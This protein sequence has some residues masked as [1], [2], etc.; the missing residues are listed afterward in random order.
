M[1]L[2]ARR[3]KKSEEKDEK[4]NTR[5][6]EVFQAL[7][8]AIDG[9]ALSKL[10][11]FPRRYYS[12]DPDGSG[13]RVVLVE[14]DGPGVVRLVSDEALINDI[15]TYTRYDLAEFKAFQITYRQAADAAKYWRSISKPVCMPAPFRWPGEAG[16]TFRRLP[17]PPFID[18][19]GTHTKT[20]NTLLAKMS[21]AQAFVAWIGSLFFGEAD[22]H[23]Y[24]WLFSTGGHGKGCINRFLARVFGPAYCSKQPPGMSD[25]YW[26]HGLM[27]KRLVVFPDCNNHKFVSSGLFK[28]LTGGDPIDVEAKYAMGFTIKPNCKF[29]FLSNERP[30]ISSEKADQRRVIYC[31]LNGESVWEADFEDRLWAEGGAFLGTCM[32]YY[33]GYYPNGGPVLSDAEEIAN[34]V[35]TLESEYQETFDTYFN[36]TPDEDEFKKNWVTKGLNKKLM[37]IFRNDERRVREFL[38]WM[39]RTHG[40]KYQTVRHGLTTWKAYKRLAA[41]D[42][43]PPH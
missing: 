22:I 19:D 31:E 15:L 32:D 25:K 20:W 26:T 23:Q 34:W 36:A 29:L 43:F 21:N 18:S 38:N 27:G 9:E 10:P 13:A 33:R 39:L 24:V 16:M 17:W 7:T 6:I 42:V 11:P 30:T 1:D 14:G 4:D 37:E 12:C 2:T 28:S 41:K 35:E 5:L 3:K 8:D 40:I